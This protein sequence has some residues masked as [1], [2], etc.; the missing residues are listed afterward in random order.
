MLIAD[1]FPVINR[2]PDKPLVYNV[3]WKT[4]IYFV[5]ALLIHYLEWAMFF[6]SPSGTRS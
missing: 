6:G 2:V 5:V 3:A 1:N 4:T